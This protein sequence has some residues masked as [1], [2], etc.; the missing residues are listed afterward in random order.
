MADGTRAG[1]PNATEEQILAGLAEWIRSGS[2]RTAAALVGFDDA[3]VRKWRVK[4][5]DAWR[6]VTHA[7][8]EAL[9]DRRA[10]VAK[11]CADGLHIG[12][13]QIRKRL[14]NADAL[15]PRDLA[16]LVRAL[17]EIDGTQDR[18]RRLDSGMPTEIV[19]SDARDDAALVEDIEQ[20]LADPTL[21]KAFERARSGK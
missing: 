11:D 19:Q 14:A 18:I 3:T 20:M 21:R 1:I 5:P 16:S 10:A 4:H 12:A 15:E 13:A 2:S 9:K 6:K 7:H 17:S 8:E